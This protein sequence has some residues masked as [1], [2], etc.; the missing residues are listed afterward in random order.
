MRLQ[1]R[2][3]LW[4]RARVLPGALL[5]LLPA[6]LAAQ[7]P[8][9]PPRP[10]TVRVDTTRAEP[11]DSARFRV[12]PGVLRPDT[13]PAPKDTTPHDSLL[14]APVLPSRPEPEPPAFW[15]GIWEWD[16]EALRRFHGTSLLE[17]V[18][19]IPGVVATRAGGFGQPVGISPFGLGGGRARIFIDG[20]EVD[21]LSASVVDLQQ[22]SPLDVESLRVERHL[23]ELRI[24]IT[25]FRLPDRRAFSQ[26]EAATG[27]P[28][29]R[30]LRGLY[31]QALGGRTVVTLG[32]DLT[33]TRGFRNQ[34]PFGVTTGV[35][36]VDH[37]FSPDAG[38]QLEYRQTEVERTRSLF[39]IGE[40][41]ELLLRARWR[42]RPG[43]F[44]DGVVGRASRS[45]EGS[46]PFPE[47]TVDQLALRA[48]L[49][50][51]PGWV[52]G[53]ARVR[54]EPQR[55]FGVP[56]S[57][58]SLRAGARPLPLLE[59]RAEARLAASGGEAGAELRGVVRV[60]PFAGVSL[61]ASAAA[62]TRGIGY[63]R[64]D[65]VVAVAPD[66][67]GSPRADTLLAFGTL[68]SALAGLRAGAEWRRGSALAGAALLRL[69][70]GQV[71]PFGLP[72]DAG[73]LP[74]EGEASTGV[75]IYVSTPVFTQGL[76]L[77]GG[78]FRWAETVPR[79]Y[80]PQQ[81]GR[82]A[83]E[84]HRLFY[85]GNLEPTFRLEA[86]HRGRARLARAP[87]SIGSDPAGA[88]STPY[89]LFNFFFQLRI[90]DVRAF[91]YVENLF[92]LRGAADIPGFP[93]PGGRLVYGV[94]WHFRD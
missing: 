65:T 41:S 37:L 11:R 91:A 78:Y 4:E 48:L 24:H 13:L 6:A 2:S 31:A 76:R 18:V 68:S 61:F 58:L 53:E 29:T 23:G 7:E 45:P 35:A 93:F 69:D 47:T 92:N 27:E 67:L 16:R 40:R 21:P 54:R 32:F 26:I 85:T 81:E 66:S 25:P 94:R 82:A 80:L 12:P 9:A 17:L 15:N 59:G 79:P 19:R 57:D 56:G 8:P 62:G 49:A 90:I 38:V 36:R 39:E 84:Y 70:P 28:E 60:G 1:L 86:V 46:D 30:F 20:W 10:D 64:G 42:P 55:T 44:L 73:R 34:Q 22:I 77:E 83:L 50:G 63:L 5:L 51:G 52:E 74:E 71:A 72:F 87:E 43:L 89:T 3:C 33:D 14:P 75:E 88:L